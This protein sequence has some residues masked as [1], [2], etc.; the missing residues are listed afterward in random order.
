[1][2]YINCIFNKT[3]FIFII[4]YIIHRIYYNNILKIDDFLDILPKIN[5]TENKNPTLKEIFKSRQLFINNKSITKEY[6]QFIRP[7]NITEEKEHKM[8]KSKRLKFNHIKNKLQNR[9][10]KL[11]FETYSKI[12]IEEK[13]I[14]ANENFQI[15]DPYISII[16]P[17]YNKQN[18]IM[19]SIRSIQN[20]SL[21]NI[22]II[23]V[24]D[25]STDNINTYYNYLLKT[26][27]RIRI[28]YHSENMG[29]WRSRIDGYL[30]SNGK[31]VIHFDTGD[32]YEDNYVLEDAY[33]TIE[34]YKLDSIKML[35]RI[36][37]NFSFIEK[38]KLPIKFDRNKSKIIYKPNIEK[39]NRKIFGNYTNIWNRLTR[40][41]IYAKGLKLLNSYILNI[42]KNLWED[43]WWNKITDLVSYDFLT[44]DRY[45][46][47]YFKDGTGEGSF[48]NKKFNKDL[49]IQ[50]FIHFL[51]FNLNLLPK[52]NN[53]K[54][55]INKINQYYISTEI[56]L[57]DFKTKFFILNDLLKVLIK[58]RFISIKDKF[59]LSKLLKESIKREKY[60]SC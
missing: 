34:K 41:S 52:R 58:D 19:K 20:Q 28:F 8:E 2:E 18:T 22:E 21:K 6:I 13:L 15:Q 38:Y 29:V 47:L 23:I 5:L 3:C 60:L 40:S 31:Y 32:L 25:C 39:Y 42:Y 48:K 57:N 43:I 12:C 56:N 51:Y 27:P 1:M 26:E 44:I 50:E 17:S 30:Y 9:N 7:I 45:S 16:L 14:N 55:I 53:K 37:K 4:V 33:N 36:I 49:I 35:F 10:D 24:D 59:F 46:Y 11:S 54:I